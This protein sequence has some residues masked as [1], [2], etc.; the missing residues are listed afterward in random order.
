MKKMVTYRR[1]VEV[2][3]PDWVQWGDLDIVEDMTLSLKP[4]ITDEHL[5]R[6]I[7]NAPWSNPDER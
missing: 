6:A 2:E 7:N 5:Q 1:K 3:V 4:D